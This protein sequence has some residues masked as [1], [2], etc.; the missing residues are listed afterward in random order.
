MTRGLIAALLL[1]ISGVGFAADTYTELYVEP[2]ATN[3]S[4][5]NGGSSRDR[6]FQRTNGNWNSSTKV[7]T[8]TGDTL[9]TAWIGEIACVCNDGTT[10]GAYFAIVTAVDNTAKTITLSSTRSAG[11][12]PTTSTG[13]RTITIGGAW[14]GMSGSTT[15]PVSSTTS[16]ASLAEDSSKTVRINYIGDFSVTS[17]I[18]ATTADIVHSGCGGTPGDGVLSKWQYDGSGD[19]AVFSATGS[20]ARITLESIWLRNQSGAGTASTQRGV[21]FAPTTGSLQMSRC[22]VSDCSAHAVYVGAFTAILQG[23]EIYNCNTAVGSTN[24]MIT[25]TTGSILKLDR[26]MIHDANNQST[27]AINST[28]TLMVSNSVFDEG[29]STLS[30]AI[31]HTT[32]ACAID[33]CVFHDWGTAIDSTTAAQSSSGCVFS[34]IIT[35]AIKVPSNVRH[36]SRQNAFFNCAA[37]MSGSG[38]LVESGSVALTRTPFVDATNGDFRTK[39]TNLRGAIDGSLL[40]S[41]SYYSKTTSFRRDIGI[42]PSNPHYNGK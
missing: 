3:A 13:S 5:I 12:A 31:K 22:R 30:I 33:N 20:T 28:G 1:L 4:N 21:L 27:G 7:F 34:D 23:C 19:V 16:F 9:N 29:N 6:K 17:T 18:T 14:A 39:E 37:K 10:A 2:E 24:G 40:Q 15:F 35:E 25:G 26:C 36:Y 41:S 11:T 42:G 32:G 38:R 8:A